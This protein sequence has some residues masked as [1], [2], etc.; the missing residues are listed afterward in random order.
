MKAKRPDRRTYALATRLGNVRVTED[1]GGFGV[2][3]HAYH[4]DSHGGYGET[5]GE[6]L[7]HLLA[8][9]AKTASDVRALKKLAPALKRNSRAK[10][11]R[12]AP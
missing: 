5:L 2:E 9:L 6:A 4:S 12:G 11:D 3:F 1:D 10:K 8:D 7:D